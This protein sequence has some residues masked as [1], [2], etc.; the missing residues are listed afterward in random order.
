[1]PAGPD[2]GPEPP[3]RSGLWTVERTTQRPAGGSPS[4]RRCRP[5]V[6]R[7]EAG[8]LSSLMWTRAL[9]GARRAVRARNT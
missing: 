2:P 4:P 1:M 8:A 6:F 9:G 7:M 3:S 5:R